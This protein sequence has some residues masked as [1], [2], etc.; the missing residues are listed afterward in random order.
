MLA[1]L[2]QSGATP[3]ARVWLTLNVP[4]PELLVLGQQP[5]PFK[6]HLICNA[7]PQGFGANHN[8]AFKHEQAQSTPAA[9][10]AVL[11]P[12]MAWSVDPFR[13]LL[14]AAQEPMTGCVY[15][16]QL[17]PLGRE[18]DHR[19]ALPSPRNLAL[20]WLGSRSS[21]ALKL[22]V[23][24]WVNAAFLVF[25]TPV[26]ATVGGFD[27]G[28]FM[29]CEDV[30]ICLRLQLAGYRLVEASQAHV[31]HDAR[32]ASHRDARH[33][34][35]HLRS[36]WRLWHSAPYRRFQAQRSVVTIQG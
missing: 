35:W 9:F 6:L 32:R 27:P 19:R 5:W 13:T 17:D 15:P 3:L 26:Y 8:Q 29:Y 11:N 23:P 7:T 4:E 10:F 16:L 2:A 31:V 30:D 18:Q 21:P 25:P 28:Y 12:D 34:F 20:R 24:D 14:A 1:L 36:L 33:L 22:A